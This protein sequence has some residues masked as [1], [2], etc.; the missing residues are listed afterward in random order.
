ML[1]RDYFRA[2]FRR[3]RSIW[4]SMI[5]A[6]QRRKQEYRRPQY[7]PNQQ[8]SFVERVKSSR[9]GRALK[10]GVDKLY[11]T[12]VCLRP[13]L[14]YLGKQY[15]RKKIRLDTIVTQNNVHYEYSHPITKR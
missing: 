14:M 7:V 9:I 8:A 2:R 1:S 15:K 4:H 6:F 10:S 5:K 3:R 11:K 13:R 12:Y